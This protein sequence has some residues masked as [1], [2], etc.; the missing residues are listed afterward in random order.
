MTFTTT[1]QLPIIHISVPYTDLKPSIYTHIHSEWQQEGDFQPNNKLHKIYPNVHGILPLSSQFS[2][3]D[4][5]VYNRLRIGQLSNT[6]V[7]SKQRSPT[8]VYAIF[9]R[10]FS[11]RMY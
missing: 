1:I 3:R 6:F 7:S 9:Y 4:Q 2:G 5:V 10:A 8:T 11:H